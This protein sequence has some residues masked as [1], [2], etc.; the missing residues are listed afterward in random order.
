M[1]RQERRKRRLM[2]RRIVSLVTLCA[3]VATVVLLVSALTKATERDA[4]QPDA[5]AEKTSAVIPTPPAIP[6]A[7][8]PAAR[9]V[10]RD[11]E[12]PEQ[13]Q[14]E[15]QPEEISRYAD[16]DISEEDIELLAALA[17]HEARGEC[18]DGQV[19]VIEV[20]LNRCLSPEFPD[21]VEGVVFQKYGDVWQFSP[22]PYIWTAEPTQ[23]QYD[24]VYTAIE[25]TDYI[26]PVET[27]FFSR[28][29]Y[30]EHVVATIGNHVFCSI[31]EVTQ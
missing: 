11:A 3:I 25:S 14:E 31:E 16:L 2:R 4:Q 8:P 10:E 26:L 19:A 12:Q 1:T 5:V 20:V 7:Q 21:T 15:A 17:Y 27:V 24:A 23:T 22:A 28:K 6:T 18:F 29:A 13:A 30:N 9:P